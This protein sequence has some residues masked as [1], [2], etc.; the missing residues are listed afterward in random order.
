MYRTTCS[1]EKTHSQTDLKHQFEHSQYTGSSYISGKDWRA[2]NYSLGGFQRKHYRARQTREIDM[3]PLLDVLKRIDDIDT[4]IEGRWKTRKKESNDLADISVRDSNATGDNVLENRQKYKNDS[5]HLSKPISYNDSDVDDFPKDD[6]AAGPLNVDRDKCIS[7]PVLKRHDTF[8]DLKS[9]FDTMD[10]VSNFASEEEFDEF[11]DKFEQKENNSN[12]VINNTESKKNR[13]EDDTGHTDESEEDVFSDSSEDIFYDNNNS[14]TGFKVDQPVKSN[15]N[16]RKNESEKTMKTNLGVKDNYA[17]TIESF[18][19][20]C[21]DL[22][23]TN[24]D[25]DDSEL[26]WRSRGYDND[27]FVS[28]KSVSGS[29]LIDCYNKAKSRHSSKSSNYS[30]RSGSCTPKKYENESGRTTP[31]AKPSRLFNNPSSAPVTRQS[32]NRNL[33]PDGTLLRKTGQL[34]GQNSDPAS[35]INSTR[36][37]S[38]KADSYVSQSDIPNKQADS[39]ERDSRE[40]VQGGSGGGGVRVAELRAALEREIARANAN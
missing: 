2:S 20:I 5:F 37:F 28:R 29:E 33:L 7:P 15:V 17:P 21:E 22:D 34:F 24:S 14:S 30:S 12:S 19:R 27:F 9:D 31:L 8:T 13:Y 23:E 35:R 16:C 39:H 10:E 18:D 36:R 4:S 6:K 38:E 3:T 32:S 11:I 1:F 40:S 26:S 25:T